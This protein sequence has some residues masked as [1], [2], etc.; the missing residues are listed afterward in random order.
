MQS[1]TFPTGGQGVY[2]ISAQ[3]IG[4]TSTNQITFYGSFTKI[5]LVSMLVHNGTKTGVS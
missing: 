5:Q 2:V 4:G 1:F 3:C